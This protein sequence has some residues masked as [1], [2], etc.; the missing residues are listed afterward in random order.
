MVSFQGWKLAAGVNTPSASHHK[1]FAEIAGVESEK[2]KPWEERLS[3][4]V[5]TPM[6]KKRL[7]AWTVFL[8]WFKKAFRKLELYMGPRHNLKR[9]YI[10]IYL[11]TPNSDAYR[12]I[13][14]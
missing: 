5:A 2:I 4:W 11:S 3:K 7:D 14:G 13:P 6:S 10:I 1:T 8:L 12:Y 9:R